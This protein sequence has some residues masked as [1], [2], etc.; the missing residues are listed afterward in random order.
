MTQRHEG[1][2]TTG[3]GPRHE[4][5][6]VRPR[7]ILAFTAGV[8]AALAISLIVTWWLFRLMASATAP[9]GGVAAARA[10]P[11]AP[12]LQVTPSQDLDAVR[13]AEID[14]L[15]S[16]GWVDRRAGIVHI[17]IDR[18]FDLIVAEGK[19]KP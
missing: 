5:T 8:L 15:S 13:A 3:A 14:R 2:V 1:D 10:V 4:M 9:A 16:Y 7:P 11:P 17:P 18:A 12:R 19:E 6:D